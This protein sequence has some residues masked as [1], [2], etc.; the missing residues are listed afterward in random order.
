M[1][2]LGPKPYFAGGADF[3]CCRGESGRSAYHERSEIR[4][5]VLITSYDLAIMMA[6]S[7]EIANT[8]FFKRRKRRVRS[9]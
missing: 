4:L 3:E 5:P 6:L 9:E 1:S 7:S 8:M 2:V